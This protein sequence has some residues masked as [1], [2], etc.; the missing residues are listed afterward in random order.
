MG[1]P[2]STTHLGAPPPLL[3][4]NLHLTGG[5]DTTGLMNDFPQN[6]HCGV[7]KIYSGIEKRFPVGG[8]DD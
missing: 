1:S 2:Q 6:D 8:G 4:I 5:P 7:S 3:G